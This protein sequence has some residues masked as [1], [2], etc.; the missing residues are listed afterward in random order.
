MHRACLVPLLVFLAGCNTFHQDHAAPIA[1]DLAVTHVD[2]VEVVS[3]RI[4][5]NQTVLVA[6]DRIVEVAPATRVRIPLAA[7]RVDGNGKYLVPGL[8][9]MYSSV[10]DPHARGEAVM[11]LYV[12]HGVVG[13]RDTGTEM[14]LTDLARLRDDLARGALL[15]PLPVILERG[16]VLLE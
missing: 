4:L 11:P 12:A 14:P 2:V 5:P 6:G 15:G 3:S 7:R 8:W 10:A 13:V 16:L 9:D 1:A